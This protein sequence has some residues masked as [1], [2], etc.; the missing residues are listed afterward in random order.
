MSERSDAIAHA[1][2]IYVQVL[3]ARGIDFDAKFPGLRNQFWD[4]HE[5]H[6][7]KACEAILRS[8]EVEIRAPKS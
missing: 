1:F 7:L 3:E 5:H 6:K 4:A 8:L 2:N